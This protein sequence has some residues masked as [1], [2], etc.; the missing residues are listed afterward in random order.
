M[1]LVGI[2]VLIMGLAFAVVAIFL[3][4]ALNNL[5]KVLSG[6]N[7]T[8]QELPEQLDGVMKETSV[9]L[10]N[11]NET[12]ADV[13]EKIHALSPLFYIIGDIG[14]SSRQL[15]SSLVHATETMRER[16]DPEGKSKLSNEQVRGAYSAVSTIYYF[17][18]KRKAIQEA[19]KQRQ[20]SSSSAAPGSTVDHPPQQT[21]D[22]LPKNPY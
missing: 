19:R 14:E 11:S 20:E 7:E 3:V 13:N 21:E 18:Q 6:V 8:V 12:L 16:Q 22:T 5:A 10:N 9:V 15:T 1:D 17:L 2:G 4:K